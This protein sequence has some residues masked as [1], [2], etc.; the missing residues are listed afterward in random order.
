MHIRVRAPLLSA[1]LSMV[2][3]W[4]M[5]C[6]LRRARALDDREQTPGLVARQRPARR[7]RHRVALA[8]LVVLV[9]RQ[10]LGSAPHVLAVGRMTHHALDGDRDGLVHLVAHDLAG[11][12]TH[13]LGVDWCLRV[14]MILTPAPACAGAVVLHG[15]HARDVLAD[16]AEL[17]GLDGL[18]G[19]TLQ[20]QRELL[21]AQRQQLLLQLR[22]RLVAQFLAFISAPAASRKWWTPTAWRRRGGTPRARLSSLTPSISNSTL[23]GLTLAIQYSTLPLP[24]PMRTSSGFLVIGTSGKHA[25]PD[26]AAA[27]DVARHRAARRLDL[28]RGHARAV[29]RP[30]GR[31]RRTPRYCRAVPG[32]RCCP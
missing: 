20:P 15:L 11:Q 2:R 9:V 5:T 21:L 26:L 4:I 8:C 1:A 13:R 24:L 3:S 30:S 12:R 25:D 29:G 10:Q 31:S 17:V 22:G 18:A 7:D 23:P 27:L 32:R 14:L 16:L 6:S 28:A 19:G